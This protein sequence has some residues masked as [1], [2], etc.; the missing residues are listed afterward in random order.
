[1]NLE[2]DIEKLRKDLIDYFGTALNFNP[3]AVID[4]TNIMNASAE[5][6]IDIALNNNFD[7]NSYVISDNTLK[8]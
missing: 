8:Y 2:I 5:E 4:L 6:L 3:L 1:M 7:L